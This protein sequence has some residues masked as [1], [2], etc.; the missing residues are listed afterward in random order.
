MKLVIEIS[1]AALR[2]AVEGEV[3]RAIAEMAEPIIQK[4]L[5][6]IM[7]KKS[8]RIIKGMTKNMGLELRNQLNIT[9]SD[10]MGDSPYKQK[11]FV[12]SIITAMVR[13]KLLQNIS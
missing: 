7:E 5:M 4:Q 2:N 11:A 13:E 1:D 8:D 3:G 9:I 6:E 12:T 10:A